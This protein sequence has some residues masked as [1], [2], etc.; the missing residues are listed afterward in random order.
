[1]EQVMS[2]RKIMGI[3]D[4][5]W[6]RLDN[7]ATLSVAFDKRT[8]NVVSLAVVLRGGAPKTGSIIHPD[9]AIFTPQSYALV[10]K[11]EPDQQS[12]PAQ[13]NTQATSNHP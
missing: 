9:A 6:V 11:K 7:K 4:D 8:K 12:A 3:D 5:L 2:M 1:M 10:F 13:T